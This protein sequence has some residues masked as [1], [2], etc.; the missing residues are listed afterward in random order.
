MRAHYVTL[1]QV[2]QA[3]RMSNLDVGARNLEINRVEYFI[4]G[5]GFIKSLDDI[6]ETVVKTTN[7]VPIYVRDV[8][9]VSLG[10]AQRR[11]LLDKGGVEAVGG[12][13]VV[14]FGENPL[15]VIRDLKEKITK[16]SPGLP[17]KTLDDGTKSHVT[18]VPF[19]DRSGLIQETLG[20]LN[21][22]LSH[23]I[24]ITVI[25]ILA[26]L[27]HLRSAFL[28][29]GLLPLAVLMTFITMKLFQV[30]SNIVSLSGIAI[31]IGT[32]VDMGIVL[33][34]NI[35]KRLDEAEPGTPTLHS[36][37]SGASEVAGAIFT[38]LA[39]TVVSFLP[40][41]ALQASEGKLFRPLAFTKTFALMAAFVVALTLIP[42]FAHWLLGKSR[43]ETWVV[44]GKQAAS[45]VLGLA[46]MW[47]VAWWFGFAFLCFWAYQTWRVRLPELWQRRLPFVFNLLAIIVVG[48]L[49]TTEWYPFG[50]QMGFLLNFGFVAITVG[51]LLLFFQVFLWLYPRLLDWALRNRLKSLL[52]P[53][54]LLLF[55]MLI[56]R[57]FD[58]LFDWI[59]QSVRVSRPVAALAH[60]FPGLGREFMPPLDEGSFLYMPTTSVHAAINEASDVLSKQDMA[61]EHIPEITSSVGKLGRVNSPLDPAPISMIETV[62]N[63]LPEY[64]VDASGR[65]LNYRFNPNERDLMRDRDGKPLA[66]PDGEPYQVKGHFERD[67]SGGLI[68]DE[69][70]MPFRQW[71]LP[72][73][74]ELNEGRAAWTG[75][76]SPD[77]IWDEIVRAGKMPGATS[78]P[79]LQPIAA[80]LVMLQS[81][82][83]AP[84]GIKVKGPDLET[85][86]A[87]GIQLEKALKQ[88]PSVNPN[89]VIADRIIGKP[90]LEF[91]LDRRAMARYGVRLEQ[92][93]MVIE[94]AIGGRRLTTTVEGR[95][96]YPV[97]IRYQRELRD[98]LEKLSQVLVP[99]P[100][101]AQIP[102]SQISD[103]KYQTGPQV[104]K[105]EDTFLTSY[106]IFDKQPGKA[107]V[108]VVEEVQT[109]IKGQERS[110]QLKRPPNVELV[111]AGS[112]QNQQRAAQ[113][114]MIIV[115]VSLFFIFIL[116][117]LQFRKVTTTALIFSSIAVAWSGGFI[118]LWLYGQPWFLDFSLFGVH[119]GKLFG[120]GPVNLSVAV[121]VGF[122]ALFG[123]ASDDGVLIA[124]YL[125]DSFKEKQP[126]TRDAIREA[127]HFAGLRRV[128]P[129]LMTTATTL[130]ALVPI[131]TSTGRGSDIMKPM[132]IPIFGGM[133]IEILT[134]LVVPMLY[135]LVADL[136]RTWVQDTST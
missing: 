103:L 126:A 38:A 33:V 61:F 128:R 22:A 44:R 15:A 77:D 111:Y 5:L 123:I 91:H 120:V 78:A 7:N 109:F 1:D 23:E 19:Y 71:R 29:S 53:G 82:M 87:Y 105:S 45:L 39:T 85:I 25:V 117:Y 34:E 106:V 56:W 100:S 83:R 96:R 58:R 97:R 16:I 28:V 50:P 18:I 46:G 57:G 90:Y 135:S 10:P 102:L 67:D 129:A 108:D 93:Q 110:G 55:G 64:V 133:A 47:W 113:R 60:A 99:T 42:T 68:P 94:M 13:V 41:F 74:P 36:I 107:E 130:I 76:K 6:R 101:G 79:R 24:L 54:V 69:R 26:M 119:V 65:R 104:I 80:R 31:A 132:A 81:G 37:Y 14:R 124:T 112:Y 48:G 95:E 11:G 118:L 21:T 125:E 86:E 40:V 75:I 92:V 88:V 122:L 115:P 63:Y 114:L 73:E 51:G 3:V 12:V 72:L 30:D 121:W 136:K 116:L 52:V 9:V 62:I 49:L 59:P 43:S 131:L 84:M 2:F 134:I 66:A 35:L 98:D 27:M 127:T 89:S 20:T 17:M 70:G 8:A 4:R 32:L